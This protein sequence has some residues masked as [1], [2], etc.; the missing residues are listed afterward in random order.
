MELFVSVVLTGA[1]VGSVYALVGLAVGFLYR[2]TGLLNLAFGEFLMLG[3]LMTYTAKVN[4]GW[5][6]LP[7]AIVGVAAG[8]A[9]NAFIDV[10]LVRRMRTPDPLRIAVMTF[11]AALI[12]RGI[13]RM[14]WGTDIYSLPT[15]PGV[16]TTISVIYDRAI[17]QGQALYVFGAL[18]IVSLAI[19]LYETRTRIGWMMRAVGADSP[20]ATTLGIPAGVI[21]VSAFAIAGGMAA[22]VGVV[23]T[24]IFFMTTGGGTLLG[25]KGLVAAVVGGF[26]VRFGAVAG[27]LMLGLLEQGSGAYVGAALQDI[28]VFLLLIAVLLFKPQGFL[29]RST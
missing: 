28:S 3:A 20:M 22:L 8:A 27:G 15:F 29:A 7:A 6:L 18:I 14:V 10:A 23:T 2:S 5:P 13:A 4:W 12:I 1:M 16:P 21:V 26:D 19:Y 11:G 25:L 9:A 24:P 17:L